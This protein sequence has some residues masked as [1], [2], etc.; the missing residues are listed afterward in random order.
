VRALAA[1][2]PG[3]AAVHWAGCGRRCGLPADATAV[4]ATASDRFTLGDG[5]AAVATASDRF[6]M[7]NDRPTFAMG[8]SGPAF[9]MGSSGPA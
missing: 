9:A 1:R 2:V 3:L 4:V 8:N 6:A 7:G 5:T